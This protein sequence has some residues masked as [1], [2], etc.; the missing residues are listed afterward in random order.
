VGLQARLALGVVPLG[1]GGG[2]GSGDRRGLE[3]GRVGDG[4]VGGWAGGGRRQA[5]G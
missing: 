2:G 5:G 3:R 4:C 1:R